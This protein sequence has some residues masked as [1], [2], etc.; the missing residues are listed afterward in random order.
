MSLEQQQSVAENF[1]KVFNEESFKQN[2]SEDDFKKYLSEKQE[3]SFK[4]GH[5]LFEDGKKP[6][7]VKTIKIWCLW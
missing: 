2:L 5:L 7:G 3:L 4:K 6:K 1:Q